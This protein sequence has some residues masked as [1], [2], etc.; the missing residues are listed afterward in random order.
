MPPT[1][2]TSPQDDPPVDPVDPSSYSNLDVLGTLQALPA[3]WG[4]LLAGLDPSVAELAPPGRTR[5]FAD[6]T[7]EQAT[8]LA[9]TLNRRPVRGGAIDAASTI[10]D[11]A[12]AVHA[13]VAGR[14]G[15]PGVRSA[16]DELLVRSLGL[17]RSAGRTLAAVGAL[18]RPVS[19]LI[20]GLYSSA[21]GVPKLPVSSV[22]VGPG[23]VAGDRQ[24]TRRH[25]GRPW[26]ALCLWSLEV[27]GRLVAE[28]H[29]IAPGSAGE[30]V[31]VAGLDWAAVRPG[32]RLRLGRDVVADV[33][34][35]ALPCTKNAQWF[36]DGE[37]NRMH[38]EREPGISRVYASVLHGGHVATG[39]PVELLP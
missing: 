14:V 27:V 10:G 12:G 5:T 39:D 22:D 24:R 21:G 18:G 11:L 6:L 20:H 13:A 29:P 2:D 4:L 32:T 26:Q 8:V 31:S 17:L 33:S 36:L 9:A 37:F 3:W 28:G 35:F 19:G 30:N 23:G 16:L 15:D 25:H 7:T 38:H 1:L 34:M